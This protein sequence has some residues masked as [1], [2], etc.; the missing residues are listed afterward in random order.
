MSY[1]CAKPQSERGSARVM[2]VVLG[3]VLALLGS[4]AGVAAEKPLPVAKPEKFDLSAEQLARIDDVVNNAIKKGELPGAVVVIV[5]RGHIVFRKAYGHRRLEPDRTLMGPEIVFDLA[6]LTKPI[7]TA[8]SIF[9][10]LEQGKLRLTDLVSQHVP[11][12]PFQG[13]K[14]T[15]AHLLTHTSGLV[16]DNAL[17]DYQDGRAKALERI[18]ALKPKAE[19]GTQFIYSDVGYIVLGDLVERVSGMPLDRFAQKNV[20]APLGMNET[21]FRPQ[22]ELA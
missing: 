5:H 10:L 3:G 16:A 13:A 18:Y 11:G 21:G 22:G 2:G 19:P 20:F 9:V 12:M 7:A 15:V 17:A 6:S 14:I 4:G 1:A 8:T